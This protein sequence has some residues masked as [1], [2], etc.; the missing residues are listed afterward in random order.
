M[1]RPL[2]SK[3]LKYEL[4]TTPRSSSCKSCSNECISLAIY[5][6]CVWGEIAC[7][8]IGFNVQAG[9]SP[10]VPQEAVNAEVTKMIEQGAAD[11]MLGLTQA[12]QPRQQFTVTAIISSFRLDCTFSQSFEDSWTAN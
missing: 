3:T 10:A 12:A 5:L 4:P 8:H 11:D 9:A 7:S 6:F 2:V 1:D